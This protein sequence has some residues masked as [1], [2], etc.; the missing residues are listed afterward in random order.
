MKLNLG[1]GSKKL[2]GWLNVDKAATFAPDRVLDLECLPWPWK[3]DAADEVALIHVL[4]HLGRDPEI[5]LGIMKEL[6]RVSRH[7]A[8]ITVVV[9]HPRHD[10]F[11]IDPTHVRPIL[12]ET[13]QM[14]SKV[15]CREWQATRVATTPLALH[16]DVDFELT[17]VEMDLDP[18][19]H[20]RVN[21]GTLTQNEAIEAILRFNNVVSQISMDLRV[22]KS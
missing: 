11:I 22:V 3:D 10:H 15:K 7:G 9:P 5:F 17:R 1:C 20:Q 19:W 4:E 6:Y 18:A 12:P 8:K 14:F 21:E 2:E 16:L 13:L